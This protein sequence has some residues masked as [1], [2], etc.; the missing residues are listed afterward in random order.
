MKYLKINQAIGTD[1]SKTSKIFSKKKI[2]L[3]FLLYFVDQLL[4]EKGNFW[5]ILKE[6][7]QL[8]NGYLTIKTLTLVPGKQSN[9]SFPIPF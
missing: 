3:K 1:Y 6:S 5:P 7:N 8:K 9:P 2:I 4:S